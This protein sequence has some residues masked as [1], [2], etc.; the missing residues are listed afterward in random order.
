M[1]EERLQSAVQ[2]AV[3][4]LVSGK[5]FELEALS[6]GRRLSAAELEQ[7]V[8]DYGRELTNEP[9]GKCSWRERVEIRSPENREG[10]SLY[11]DLW[12]VEEGRS[13]LTLEL[14]VWESADGGLEVEIDDLHVL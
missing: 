13:D 4:L 1:N 7:A 14:T 6:G 10:W 9:G 5:Y 2:H 11:V 3:D 8:R 12:T